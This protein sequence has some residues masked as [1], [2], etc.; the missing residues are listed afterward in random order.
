MLMLTQFISNSNT[1]QKQ[2]RQIRGIDYVGF[3]C[4]NIVI[5]K[6]GEDFF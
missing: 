2:F 4:Y 5:K 3:I 6:G 1:F